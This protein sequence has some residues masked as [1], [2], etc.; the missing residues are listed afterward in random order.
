MDLKQ[1]RTLTGLTQQQLAKLAGLE[2]SAI[3]DIEIGRNRRPSHEAVTRIVRAFQR[4]GLPGI[5]AEDLFPV[6]DVDV[7]APAQ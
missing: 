4:S 5:A 3:S 1:A 7:E 2:Q 6:P